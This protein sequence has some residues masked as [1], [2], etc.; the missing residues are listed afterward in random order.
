MSDVPI[1]ESMH[2]TMRFLL[3]KSLA[4]QG[5]GTVQSKLCKLLPDP[6]SSLHDVI[7]S[8]PK[9]PGQAGFA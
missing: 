6:H 5:A 4:A 3:W 8:A 9:R 7:T 2:M 1:A